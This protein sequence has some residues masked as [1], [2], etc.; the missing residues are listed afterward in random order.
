MLILASAASRA[1]AQIAR[2]SAYWF[3]KVV[4]TE[5]SRQ[6]YVGLNANMWVLYD[7]P[8]AALYQA[9]KGGALGGRLANASPT[10]TPEYWFKGGPHFAH[11][12]V[13]SGT[14]YFRDAVGEYFASYTK[15]ADID[16]YYTKWPK[17]PLNYRNWVVMNGATDAE[18]TVRYRGY[19]VLGNGFTLKFGLLL[20]DKTEIS[21]QESPEFSAA[22][23]K[24]NLVRTFTFSGIPAGYQVR[25][26]HPGGSAAAWSVTSGSA[27]LAA[28]VMTQ[29]ADG[30]T[31][32]T[33]SW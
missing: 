30:Q 33:G 1:S 24:N 19:S 12:F 28:G 11:I 18:A 21:V 9:W 7:L 5:R 23:G 32:L 27:A 4:T 2:P 20:P 29:T 31:V 15:P 25:L 3:G 26:Q 10:V 16:L 22:N 6:V 17:Q 14:N 13:P 8:Q